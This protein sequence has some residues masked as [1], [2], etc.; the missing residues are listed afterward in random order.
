MREVLDAL[1]W[2]RPQVFRRGSPDFI[3]QRQ[4]E[5]RVTEICRGLLRKAKSSANFRGQTTENGEENL[6]HRR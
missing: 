1:E 3:R 2:V 5:A 4:A 6:R